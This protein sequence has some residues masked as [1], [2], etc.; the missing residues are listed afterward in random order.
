M[1]RTIA[2]LAAAL[3]GAG[4]IPVSAKADGCIGQKPASLYGTI[5]SAHSGYFTLRDSTGRHI[6]VNKQDAH[7]DYDGLSLNPGVYA[8]VYGCT[9][10]GQRAFTAEIV[11]LASS[12]Q[13]YPSRYRYTSDDKY[14]DGTVMETHPGQILIHST[15]G[16]HGDVWVMTNQSGFSQ[17]QPIHAT[18]YFIEG[19]RGFVASNI[20]VARN[21]GTNG[22]AQVQGQIREVKPG[23]V[24]VRE[25]TR[26]SDVWVITNAA[27]LRPGETIYAT[28]HFDQN[29][30]FVASNIQVK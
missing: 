26:N 29:R 23:R 21:P 5:V 14:V 25:Q 10:S 20:S 4:L 15:S 11:T 24:L 18:G 22:T 27:N 13:T 2:F 28:G 30:Q 16:G 17:G 1:K 19:D 9:I 7:L 8:G 12:A 6:D 3:L